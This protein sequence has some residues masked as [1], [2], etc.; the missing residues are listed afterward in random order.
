MGL[1]KNPYKIFNNY[2]LRTPLFSVDFFKS[3]TKNK[4]TTDEELKNICQNKRIKEA[5][6]LASPDL[7]N[8]LNK[9]LN[10]KLNDEKSENIKY[11]VFK[12]L[13]RMSSRCTPFGLFAGTTVG[14]FS[15]STHIELDE[16]F[17]NTRHTRLDMNYLVALTQTII[18]VEAIRDQLQFYPNT[19]LYKVG[20]QFRY[21]EYSYINTKRIHHIVGANYTWYLDK[22]IKESKRGKTIKQLAL[23]ITNDDILFEEAFNYITE[24]IE[25]QILISELEPSVSGPEFLEHILTVLKKLDYTETII[26]ILEKVDSSLHKID[27]SI[28][29]NISEYLKIGELIKPLNTTFELK[30]LFQ[31][32]MILSCKKNTLDYS[33]LK[34]IKSVL[35]LLNKFSFAQNETPLSQFKTAFYERYET[36]PITLSKA[37]DKELG[38][39]F[40][41]N[42]DYGDVSVLV[43]DLKLPLNPN[44]SKEYKVTANVLQDILQNKLMECIKSNRDVLIINDKDFDDLD[45]EEDWSD[46]PDTMS[47]MIEVINLEGKEK[48]SMSYM[49]GSSAVN[50]LGRFCHG[51]HNIKRHVK[52]IIDIETNI[53]KD[54][55]LAE[56]VHLPE[57]RVGNILFRPHLRDYE[58]PYLANSTIK[59]AN[60]INIEDLEIV[61]K[62]PNRIAIKS[63]KHN[64]EVIPRLSNA[65]NFSNGSLP[66]YQFLA[67]VQNNDKRSGIGFS[68][69]A[70]ADKFDFLP[71]VEYKEVVLSCKLWNLKKADIQPVINVINKDS[72]FSNAIKELVNSKNLPQFV[73]LK[74]GDNELLINFNNLLS[75]KMLLNTIKKRSKFQLKEFLHA[76]DGIIKES[77]NNYSNQIVVSFFNEEKLINAN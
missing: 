60:Q 51:D 24:L 61:A 65:H 31:T 63:K 38:I 66:V 8:E 71:R 4:N 7:S 20:R 47:S 1:V 48:I 58:I 64:K 6:F 30:Y 40:L 45:L 5:I 19:S 52:Q 3:I 62:S 22:I 44:T 18:E 14:E 73:M 39:G 56:I 68:W 28:T 11:S 13:S 59:E 76:E 49:G 23:V 77:V 15:H 17:K 21:I 16:N 33:I 55:I 35:S 43:D 36:T 9:W 74:D 54:K 70:L 72:E 50:L 2:V 12:Y 41:Q 53:N 57:S 25:S 10:G 27:K 69:G 67:C 46:L 26:S 34:K 75:V 42:N 37:L 29:N 32:D